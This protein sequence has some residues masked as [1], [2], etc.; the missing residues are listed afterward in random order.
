MLLPLRRTN[1]G[2]RRANRIGL[3]ASRFDRRT[4]I[5]QRLCK[6][7]QPPCR[8]ARLADRGPWAGNSDA[9][10]ARDGEPLPD[11]RSPKQVSAVPRL[12]KAKEPGLALVSAGRAWAWGAGRRPVS[13]IAPSDSVP[14][15]RALHFSPESAVARE[16]EPRAAEAVDEA[17]DAG[18]DTEREAALAEVRPDKQGATDRIRG[19]GPWP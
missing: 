14:C 1:R 11:A 17:K 5:S 16:R 18:Q 9:V 10:P 15:K 8:L 2:G 12:G 4:A 13:G 6:S 7:R 19:R 3:K